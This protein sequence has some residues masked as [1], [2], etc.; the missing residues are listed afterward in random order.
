MLTCRNL[1]HQHDLLSDLSCGLVSRASRKAAH[2]EL[3]D[4]GILGRL[5]QVRRPLPHRLIHIGRADPGQCGRLHQ[6]KSSN[7]LSNCTFVVE[8][9][10][11]V[12]IPPSA[13]LIH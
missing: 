9:S 12:I 6:I 11:E 2:L 3:L 5:A 4:A 13:R 10:K 1:T 8:F 7:L